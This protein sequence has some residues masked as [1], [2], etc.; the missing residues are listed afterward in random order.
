MPAP[1]FSG[2]YQLFRDLLIILSKYIEFVLRLQALFQ[3]CL[4]G[5]SEWAFQ[6]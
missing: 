3:L 5:L 4:N 6:F 1:L 2:L